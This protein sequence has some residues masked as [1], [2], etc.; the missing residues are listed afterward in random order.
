L[1]PGQVG[2]ATGEINVGPSGTQLDCDPAPGAACPAGDQGYFV[3]KAAHV[4]QAS[5]TPLAVALRA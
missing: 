2:G 3:V 5:Q 1:G 4:D